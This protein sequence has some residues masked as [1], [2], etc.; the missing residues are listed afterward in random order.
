MTMYTYKYLQYN[1]VLLDIL[2]EKGTLDNYKLYTGSSLS[3]D[4]WKKQ[5]TSAENWAKYAHENNLHYPVTVY[6]NDKPHCFI[7]ISPLFIEVKFLDERMF[8]FVSLTFDRSKQEGQVF[9]SEAWVRE[10]AYEH[11][12]PL[13]D[14]AG[15]QHIVFYT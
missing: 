15:D 6:K 9:L 5:S 13:K 14:L 7:A 3:K 4:E 12:K 8:W 1:E 10:Y 11:E 2:D